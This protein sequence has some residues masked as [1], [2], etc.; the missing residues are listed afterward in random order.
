[1]IQRITRDLD[2]RNAGKGSAPP[3]ERVPRTLHIE[4]NVVFP[5]EFHH[6]LNMLRHGSIQ[7]VRR[8]PTQCATSLPSVRIS[9]HAGAI[10]ENRWTG[11]S[12]PLRPANADWVLR[13]EC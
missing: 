6:S 7:R 11:I 1:M 4:S 3:L 10:R 13:M 5:R 12:S 2:L 8:V 9:I